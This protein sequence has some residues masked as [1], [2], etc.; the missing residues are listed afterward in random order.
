MAKKNN[1]CGVA[2]IRA[3]N[4]PQHFNQLAEEAK[5]LFKDPKA[6]KFMIDILMRKDPKQ[7]IRPGAEFTIPMNIY[8]E[9]VL[10]NL[11]KKTFL[12]CKVDFNIKENQTL[13]HDIITEITIKDGIVTKIEKPNLKYA[14][15]D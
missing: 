3:I 14:Y 7:E 10:L 13:I 11:G 4:T 15:D 5:G 8:L 9:K 1:L 12:D 2:Y 6:N